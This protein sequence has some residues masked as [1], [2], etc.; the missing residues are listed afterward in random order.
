MKE[1]TIRVIWA[2]GVTGKKER[3]KEVGGEPVG[4]GK[5]KYAEIKEK[6][7]DRNEGKGKQK[8]NG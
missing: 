3:R 1:E 5:R 8:E 2:E 7:K 6:G 4:K